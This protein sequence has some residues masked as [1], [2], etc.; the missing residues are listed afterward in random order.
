MNIR[1]E[2]IKLELNILIKKIIRIEIEQR[3]DEHVR[4][5]VE[6]LVFDKKYEAENLLKI[7]GEQI[8]ISE[9]LENDMVTILFNGYVEDCSL[10]KEG[11]YTHIVVNGIS[12]SSQI[13][14]ERR[15]CSY[16]KIERTYRSVADEVVNRTPNALL[17]WKTENCQINNLLIQY[18]ETDWMFLKR[19]ASHLDCYIIVKEK[20]GFPSISMGIEKGKQREWDEEIDLEFEWGIDKRYYFSE[21]EGKK[22]DDYIY[23]VFQ[24]RKNYALCDYFNINGNIF[25]IVHKLI[26]FKKEELFFSYKLVKEKSLKKQRKYNQKI[27]G[28][29]LEGYVIKTEKENVYIQLKID[30]VNCA[31]YAFK[32]EPIWG[33]IA[34]CM[35][36]CGELVEARFHSADERQV[37]VSR[38]IRNN[39]A[40]EIC[41]KLGEWQNRIFKTKEEKQLRIFPKELAFENI[42]NGRIEALVEIKDDK[43]ITVD[44][45]EAININASGNIFFGAREIIAHSPQEVQLQGKESSIQ[46]NRSFNLYSPNGIENYGEDSGVQKTFVANSHKESKKWINNYNALAAIPMVNLNDSLTKMDMST[47]AALPMTGNG[48]ATYSLDE[49]MHGKEI[50][51]TSFPEVF[52]SMEVRTLN[53]G[54]PPPNLEI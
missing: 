2:R 53:G 25:I 36:E 49:I 46:I 29:S 9:I 39:N 19:I 23:Y 15:C 17:D 28:I 51:E 45:L 54:F 3:L 20:S 47:L 18:E 37:S 35:P 50:E 48:K 42:R 14:K 11:K 40:K 43:G 22:R 31:E 44:A 52:E 24:S 5:E 8:I 33:N 32:W 27:K 13:D 1:V 26:L 34:Y 12:Y 4:A 41:E 16:Q 6:L 30:D 10:I 38:S 7:K 21:I